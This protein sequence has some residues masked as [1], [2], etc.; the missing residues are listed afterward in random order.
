MIVFFLVLIDLLVKQLWNSLLLS[1]LE[2][3]YL[4]VK[5]A[6]PLL[7]VDPEFCPIADLATFNP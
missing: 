6:C 7:F 1:K 3:S 2:A 5:G 4:L